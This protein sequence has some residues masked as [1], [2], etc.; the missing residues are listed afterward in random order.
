MRKGG[1][2]YVKRKLQFRLHDKMGR[3]ENSIQTEAK[4]QSVSSSDRHFSGCALHC[5]V[6]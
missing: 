5:S 4:S 1:I 3:R 6:R 2:R